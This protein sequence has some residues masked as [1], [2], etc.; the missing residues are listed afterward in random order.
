MVRTFLMIALGGALGASARHAANLVVQRLLGPGFPWATLV[1]NV[2]GSLVMGMLVIWFAERGTMRFAPF[3]TV[4]LLGGF[5]TF[6]TFSLDA[7]ALWQRGDQ[8]AATGYVAASVVLS[9]AALLAG[10]MLA[11]GIWA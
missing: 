7:V 8:L 1:V 4:G 3:L 9:L 10:M 5:T 2:L 11:R 6:S